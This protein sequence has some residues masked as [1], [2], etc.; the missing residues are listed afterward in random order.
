MRCSE[1]LICKHQCIG[2]CGEVCPNFCVICDKQRLLKIF[3][4]KPFGDKVFIQL[5]ECGHLFDVNVLDKKIDDKQKFALIELLRCPSCD[6]P[7]Y[8]SHIYGNLIKER[9]CALE[10]VKT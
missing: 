7:I 10:R 3:K 8:K 6:K 2:I 9:L 4:G 1:I 5:E